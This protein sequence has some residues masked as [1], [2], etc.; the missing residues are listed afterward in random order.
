M[1][2]YINV[3]L[4][5]LVFI[6]LIFLIFYMQ[7]IR[8]ERIE[9]QKEA[10]VGDMKYSS[11]AID[12]NHWYI[13]DGRSLHITDYPELYNVIGKTFGSVDDLHFNLPDCRGRVLGSLGKAPSLTNREFGTMVG[14]ET[15]TMTI[16][17]LVSH[18]HT[19][20]TA[21]SGEHNHTGT[22]ATAGEHAHTGTTSTAG[23]HSH[24]NNA[25]GGQ[26][27]LGLAVADGSNTVI[28][29][30]GS[31]GELN[32]WTVPRTLTINNNGAHNHTYTTSSN[33]THTHTYTTSSNG[34]HTHTFTT[35]S[36]GSTQPFNVMQPTIYAG[37]VFIL[38]KCH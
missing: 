7:Y 18:T 32:V 35:N 23:E 27:N 25:I 20:T 34:A 1:E 38:V 6:I 16:P 29:T 37:N 24:T 3:I 30:D 13:C 33:G 17:E 5:V 36:T 11:R 14:E 22:T 8:R 4:L 31:G 26:G 9:M 19:G 2:D 21:T 15:H 28:D 10:V 12:H